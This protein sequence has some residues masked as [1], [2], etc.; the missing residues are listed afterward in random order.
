MKEK[1]F[2]VLAKELFG[3]VLTPLGFTSEQSQ[4]CT[5]Y[6]KVKD[7]IYHFV[8]PSIGSRGVWYQ[9]YVFPHSPAICPLFKA[10]FPDNLGIPTDRCSLVSQHDG[11]NITQEQFNC[12]YE[13]NFRRGFANK[14]APLLLKVAVPY[15]DRFQTVADIIPVI[16]HASFLG[17]ALHHVGRSM[18]AAAA[19]QK[20]RDRLRGLDT[21]N[22]D[23][24]T[25]LE[26][27]ERLL[28]E[29]A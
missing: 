28:K 25:L 13:E 26:H 5:F 17:F 4:R 19:L 21:T 12:K 20:E 9:I 1:E 22:K 3:S 18:E 14:V 11:V 2:R 16:R 23:V 6:R 24:A 7:E 15:L 29:R 10:K 27:V 8:M